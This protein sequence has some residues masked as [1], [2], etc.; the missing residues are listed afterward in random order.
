MSLIKNISTY[1]L[2]KKER[3]KTVKQFF[4]WNQLTKVLI[5]CY[6]N[7]LSDIVDFINSCKTD[8]IYVYVAVIFNGK[9]EQAPKPY[10]EHCILDKK[11]FSFLGPCGARSCCDA[12]RCRTLRLNLTL[13]TA[14]V[15]VMVLII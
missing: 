6:D 12:T 7:K 10:F 8:N 1:L 5:V 13:H 4:S 9:L 11:Q 15:W 14:P 3:P 2:S